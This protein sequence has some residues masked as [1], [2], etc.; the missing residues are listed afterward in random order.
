MVSD[1]TTSKFHYASSNEEAEGE[2]GKGKG[3]KKGMP[4]G[5]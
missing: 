2:G 3:K 5:S 1:V 4:H